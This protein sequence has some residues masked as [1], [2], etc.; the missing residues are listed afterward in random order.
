MNAPLRIAVLLGGD[1]NEREISLESGRNVVYKLPQP[2]YTV[3]PIFVSSRCELFHISQKLLV[4][5]ST[6]EIEAALE[7]SMR[8]Q[9]SALPSFCDFVFIG[10]HGGNGENGTIQGALEMLGL[11]YN[12]SS[13]LSSALCMDKWKTKQLLSHEGFDVP[14]G[15]IITKKDL[16]VG[17]ERWQ[18]KLPAPYPL[19]VKPHDDGC[20]VMVQKVKNEAELNVAVTAILDAGKS[21]A[22]IEECVQGIELTVG[23]MGN[24][25]VRALPPSQAVA[26]GGILSIEEKFLPGAGEN[27]TPAPI[28]AAATALVQETMERVYTTVGCSGYARIDCFLQPANISPTGKDRVIILEIN[29]LPGLTP[30]TCLFHQA[31]EIDI[32][33]GDFLDILVQLGLEKHKPHFS[34]RPEIRDILQ[35]SPPPFYSH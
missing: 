7:P 35:K 27:L 2:K 30:A 31:A 8:V 15:I 10:L 22:L 25:T 16:A 1:T 33:P 14:R 13:V 4:K 29:S 21:G 17:I 6:H 34:I 11:P 12:G 28:G 24:S 23:V 3:L 26:Q 18:K 9:W 5:N 19:I 20:S 32:R